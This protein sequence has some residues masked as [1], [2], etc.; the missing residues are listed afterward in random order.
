MNL[1]QSSEGVSEGAG[2][3]T[4]AAAK[5][6]TAQSAA[7]EA[8]ATAAKTAEATEAT[9]AAEAAETAE[10]AGDDADGA[11]ELCLLGG[12]RQGNGLQVGSLHGLNGR[13]LDGLHG[14]GL[15][16][17]HL[18]ALHCLALHL[19]HL[20]TAGDLLEDLLLDAVTMGK[21]DQLSGVGYFIK[22]AT[23]FQLTGSPAG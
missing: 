8:A 10:T 2:Q 13:Q 12:L 11:P 22:K 4:G 9:E 15:G 21:D 3:A 17:H 5:A 20:L 23:V 14:N 6:E 19:L 16:G 7:A 1:V 18:L